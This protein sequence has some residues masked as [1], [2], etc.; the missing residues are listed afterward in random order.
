MELIYE[1]RSPSGLRIFSHEPRVGAQLV[2]ALPPVHVRAAYVAVAGQPSLKPLLRRSRVAT[3]PADAGVRSLVHQAAQRHA[4]DAD[5]LFAL[6]RQESGFEP[7]AVSRAG[8]RGLMQLM[9]AT[10]RRYGVTQ[11]HDPGENIA[12]GSAYLRDLINR[13]GRLEL[14]LAAYNAGEGAVEKYGRRIPPYDETQR[15]VAAVMADYR[16]RKQAR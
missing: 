12:G 9:P 10:A 4:L 7:R 5:L 2:M 3:E 8:A 6:M 16:W 13:F 15:Y 1:S 11:I 14:A